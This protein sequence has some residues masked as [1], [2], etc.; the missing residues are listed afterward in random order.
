MVIPL[1]IIP[2]AAVPLVRA[3]PMDPLHHLSDTLVLGN[4]GSSFPGTPLAVSSTEDMQRAA[5]RAYGEPFLFC[6]T[7]HRLVLPLLTK[8]PQRSPSP[9]PSL[10]SQIQ[11]HLQ[12]LIF[13]FQSGVLDPQRFPLERS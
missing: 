1:Q 4:T 12:Q 11:L 3:F 8:L 10:F 5:R 7:A 6:A 13:P 2:N 9:A